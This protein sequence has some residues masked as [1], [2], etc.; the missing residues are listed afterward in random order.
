M[1]DTELTVVIVV[2]DE[3][4]RAG[5]RRTMQSLLSQ[6]LLSVM[7]ILIIDCSAPGTP[8]LEGSDHPN[9][10]TIHMPRERT[11]MAAA[12]AAGVRQARSPLVAFLD[13]HSFAMS[14]WAEALIRAHEGPW[15]GVGGEIYNLSSAVGVADP[16]YL[17]GH[18][19]WAPPAERKKVDL[20]PSHD[21]CYK[22][23]ILLEYDDDLE[24]LLMAEPVLMWKLRQDG[25]EL[26]L[27]PDVKS[28]HGYTANVLTLIA[29]YAWN[30]CFGYARAQV[31][32]WS[33]SRRWFHA[34]LAPL[35][36]WARAFQI[37]KM[38]ARNAPQRLWV[39]TIGLPFILLAQY[40]A[41][42][43]EAMGYL[44]GKGNAEILFTQ[45]H[46]R[47]LRWYPELP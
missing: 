27:D 45:T 3:G 35:I 42:I 44:F 43:G 30:R 10:R 14:G 29:F 28:M 26:L 6:K 23:E 1:Q 9:V 38:L 33:A 7:E 34:L 40:S 18:G 39:F 25:Y 11:T 2:G 47:G 16:I 19:R 46:L 36:P 22:R 31:F 12:R 37:G 15:A 8:P 21:T 4:T 5:L 24:L 20:L 13:E 17:M 41:S 32:N